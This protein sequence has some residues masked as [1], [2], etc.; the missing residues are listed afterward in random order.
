M[1]RQNER[2]ARP[3]R[4]DVE[5]DV[6]AP[7][8]LAEGTEWIHGAHARRA[9]RRDGADRRGAGREVFADHRVQLVGAHREPPV[10]RHL[11]HV[12]AADARDLGV[13]LGGG[14]RLRRAVDRQAVGHA[15]LVRAPVR[16]PLARR[17]DGAEDR[18]RGRVLDDA[19]KSIGQADHLPEPVEH[20]R[21][22]LRGRGR[23]LPQ[24]A[25]RAERR[26]EHLREERRRARVRRE[27]GEEARV[28][29]VRD[30]RQH[31]RGE[32]G[33]DRLHRLAALGRRERELRGDLSGLDLGAHGIALDLGQV[34]GHPVDERVGVAAEL[35]GVHDG[36]LTR[37]VGA[38]E[39][40]ALGCGIRTVS[41]VRGKHAARL[42][43]KRSS[44]VLSRRQ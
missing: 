7:A 13:L 35:R 3:R 12:G 31:D 8:H 39:S 19:V 9:E 34:V 6:V 26:G 14:V 16:R 25:L 20:A 40:L 1:V 28:L 21:L 27:V 23:R 2:A 44:A 30:P 5:E 33:E 22:H 32:V 41:N 17:E 15:R 29:P 36:Q 18:A 10:D 43:D 11:A 38:L 37:P 42:L 24:H 4:V